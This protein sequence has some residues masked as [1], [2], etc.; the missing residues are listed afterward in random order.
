MIN[1]E[2]L[3]ELLVE[4]EIISPVQ[5]TE[6]LLQQETLQLPL[7]ETLI[8][9]GYITENQLLH[10]LSQQLEVDFINL[11]END[12]HAIDRS[13]VN[14]LPLQV[15]QTHKVLPVFVLD[16]ENIRQITL[17][18]SNPLNEDAIHEVEEKT[19]CQVTPVLTISSDIDGGIRRLFQL[20]DVTREAISPEELPQIIEDRVQFVNKLLAE[21]IQLKASDIHIEPHARE[22][23]VR[24]RLDGVLHMIQ[25]LPLAE[26]PPIISR[27]KIMG[28]EHHSSMQ[29]D[30][31]NI[32]HEG[33]FARV[34]GGH[35]VDFRICT[36]PTIYGEKAALRILD[37]T[38]R[39]SIS[40]ITD[41]MMAPDT[42]RRFLRS[43]KQASGII[44]ATGPTGSG[45][46]T[47]LH[48]AINEINEVGLN[49]VTVEDPVEYH[50]GDFIN[51]SN[52]LPQVG[53]TYPRALRSLLRQDP[54]VILVGE[55]R[56]L[57]TAEIAVQAALTG[58]LVFTTMHT[59][60]AAGAVIRLVDLG[61]EEFLVSSTVVSSINQR[62][63]R[64]NC[65][66]CSEDYLP[67]REEMVDL[68]IDTEVIDEILQNVDRYTIQKGHGCPLCRNSGYQGRQGVYEFLS[69]TPAIKKMILEKETS[70]II[71]FRAREQQQLNMLFEDGLR[72]VLTG[73]TSFEEL[74]RVP[75]GD[76]PMRSIE[77]MLKIAD[78]ET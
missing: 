2:R 54:D 49:I 71:S 29:L 35:N 26:I 20:E 17:A 27:L 72:L 10:F 69:V 57:E 25:T 78:G 18:M 41:M 38:S 19:L 75:R 23:H 31:K 65:P 30:K 4:K 51:Q 64:K 74:K 77:E 12:F 62:L 48:A 59:D 46:T 42:M 8:S 3:G 16:V 11:S 13:L 7:G 32:P 21:A 73:V 45:K 56:D 36:F 67:S 22:A 63:L 24:F 1:K 70:D 34:V 60:D 6:A 39:A 43:I 58:H 68:M 9:L 52:I 40:T 44:I 66:H 28:S 50:A 53:F 47:T 55:I 76:Y 37:K 61:I 14:I 33:S 15:C 5:L